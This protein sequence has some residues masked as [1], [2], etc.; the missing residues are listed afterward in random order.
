MRIVRLEV[1]ASNFVWTPGER[2]LAGKHR[3][4]LALRKMGGHSFAV[5]KE[6]LRLKQWVFKHT[7]LSSVGFLGNHCS[8]VLNDNSSHLIHHCK[9]CGC[10]S[11]IE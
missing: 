7:K 5:G 8:S 11:E 9:K 1:T 2:L 6:L 3:G 4:R 10:S